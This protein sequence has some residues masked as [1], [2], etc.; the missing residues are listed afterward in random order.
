MNSV[1]KIWEELKRPKKKEGYSIRRFGKTNLYIA[2]TIDDRFVVLVEDI[3]NVIRKS[4]KNLEIE[5]I[6]QLITKD[7][8]KMSPQA[9]YR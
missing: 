1:H 5:N 6:K 2:K 4:Y 9:R 7:K 3:P 8:K